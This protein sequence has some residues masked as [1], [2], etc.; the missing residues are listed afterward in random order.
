MYHGELSLGQNIFIAYLPWEGYNYEDAILIN[1]RLV[2]DDVYTSLHIERYEIETQP[3]P[4]GME[5]ITANIPE[6][7]HRES[8]RL[9]EFGIIKLGSWVEEGDILVGKVTPI[10]QHFQSPY[11]RLLY[12]LLEKELPTNRDSSL[13][14]LVAYVPK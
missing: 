10:Q 2:F 13:R 6:L 3:T 9:D 12:T 4:F 11:Q 14:R 7:S 8:D 1:E 5:Q